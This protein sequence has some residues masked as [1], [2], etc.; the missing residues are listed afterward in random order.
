MPAVQI[1]TT[2]YQ[3]VH[4]RHPRGRGNWIFI[5][6]EAAMEPLDYVHA[7]MLLTYTQAVKWLR[8]NAIPGC[9]AVS[10]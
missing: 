10:S 5:P 7:P 8:R 1:D 2:N 4:G 6:D 9:Y 3:W